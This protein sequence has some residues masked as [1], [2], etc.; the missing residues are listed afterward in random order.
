MQQIQCDVVNHVD[1]EYDEFLDRLQARFDGRVSGGQPLFATDAD[2]LWGLYLNSFTDPAIR[3]YH[4]CHACRQFITR[5]GDLVTIT[6]DGRTEPALWDEADAPDECRPGIA[7]LGKAVRRAK[8]TGVFLSSDLVWG[9]PKTGVWHHMAVKPP[10]ALLYKGAASTA[11]QAMAEKR[12]DFKTVMTALNKF[13]RVNLETALALLLSDALYRSE[14]LLGQAEWLHALRVAYDAA[15]GGNR[16]NVVWRAIATAPAGF[17]HPRASMI[18]TLLEDIAAGKSYESVALN[19]AAKMNPLQYQ[20]PQAA[21]TYGAIAAAEKLLTALRAARALDRRYARLDEVQALWRPVPKITEAPVGGVFGHLKPKG[22]IETTTMA[23]PAQTMTWDKFQRTVLPTATSIACFAPMVGSYT[24]LVTAVHADAPPILQWDREDARNPVSW[25]LWKGGATAASFGLVGNQWVD[26]DAIA[27]KP[28]MWNGG[29]EHQGVG[30][31]FVLAGAHETRRCG[32]ALFP[33][34]L[35]SEFHGI[36]AVIDA[37]SKSDRAQIDGMDQP[38]AA[39][40]MIDWV[41]WT[42]KLRVWS[43]DRI[44]SQDYHIDRLD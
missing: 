34:I 42:V 21:P 23:V 44:R 22:A 36:R 29:H 1:V 20:R 10:V 9:T 40:L 43:S 24:A 30:V 13:T 4:H 26:V 32:L 2:D 3:K 18:W 14:K 37:Y 33:E 38:H 6:T 27:L 25:Y 16:A 17:C 35:K 31:L 39:G 8:V 19:F 15:H 12:E 5:V 7:A 11:G 28:S 41:T